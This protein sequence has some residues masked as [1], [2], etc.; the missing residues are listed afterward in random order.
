MIGDWVRQKHSGLLLQVSEIVPPYIFARQ[1]G[2]FV[3]DDIDPIPLTP[4]IL[5]SN[6]F[7]LVDEKDKFYRWEYGDEAWVNA[8][9][10][11]EEP[12]ACVTNTCYHS[13]P[14]CL[15][16]HQLQHA[17]LLCGIVKELKPMS[18]DSPVASRQSEDEVYKDVFGFDLSVWK[19]VPSA[20]YIAKLMNTLTLPGIYDTEIKVESARL[21]D[22]GLEEPEPGYWDSLPERVPL[23]VWSAKE[24]EKLLPPFI[25]WMSDKP[26]RL[27][28]YQ[29]K[30]E[31]Y[32][33][34]Y[35][36]NDDAREYRD[37]VLAN[38][39]AKMTLAILENP[40]LRKQYEDYYNKAKM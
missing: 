14:Y 11:A 33:V 7:V 2:Q 3:E 24:L 27:H 36:N 25:N 37:E 18:G 23:S 6:G 4:E 26:M 29:A 8:D 16:L 10:K 9:F 22:Y 28:I 32:I 15:Y 12:W 30:N 13:A 38:A 17:L 39:L 31:E 20:E 21:A 1:G 19:E 40:D 35:E 5:V 34:G